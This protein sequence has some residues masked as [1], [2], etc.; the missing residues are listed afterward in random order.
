VGETNLVSFYSPE[1]L[2][3]SNRVLSTRSTSLRLKSFEFYP[4]LY[5]ISSDSQTEPR[6]FR[7]TA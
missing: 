7:P 6:L 4:K 5:L 2:N 1:Y 3:I